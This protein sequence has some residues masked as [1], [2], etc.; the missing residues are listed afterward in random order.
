MENKVLLLLFQVTVLA[1]LI[2][3]ALSVPI[4]VHDHYAP[5]KLVQHAPVVYSHPVKYVSQAPVAYSH[6][7]KYVSHAPVAIAQAEHVQVEHYA[8]PNYEFKYGVHDAHTHDI[9]EQ[10]EKR[11]GDKVEGYYKLVEPDG[12]TRTVHYTADKHTGFNAVVEKSG[13]AVHPA[14]V[15]KKVVVP[16]KKVVSAPLVTYSHA[17][18]VYT[19]SVPTYTHS[20]PTYTYH[21]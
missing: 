20:V 9:K 5:L 8:P 10:A 16:V 11:V 19:H 21:H 4:E 17:A 15:V 12:T 2:A 6:P 1:I 14:P 13:H 18:P 7:V 3:C